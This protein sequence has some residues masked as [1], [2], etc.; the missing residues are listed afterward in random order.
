MEGEVGIKTSVLIRFA[1]KLAGNEKKHRTAAMK[2]LRKWLTA[3]SQT[4]HG[5]VA[6]SRQSSVF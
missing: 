6:L 1:Q 3:K 4:L 2:K 5:N